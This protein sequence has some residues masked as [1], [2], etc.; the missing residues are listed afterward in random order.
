MNLSLTHHVNFLVKKNYNNPLLILDKH[1]KA[2]RYWTATFNVFNCF[3]WSITDEGLSFWAPIH[4]E[5]VRL[6]DKRK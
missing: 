2:K 3:S 1:Y 6:T 4:H 5:Y